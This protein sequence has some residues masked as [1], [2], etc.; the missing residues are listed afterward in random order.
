MDA[1]FLDMIHPNHLTLR[2]PGHDLLH[3][4]LQLREDPWFRTKS[5]PPHSEESF[6]P[7]FDVRVL[8]DTFF[9][10]GEF[11]GVESSDQI[12]LSTIDSN[13]L[14]VTANVSRLDVV[15]EWNLDNVPNVPTATPGNEEVSRHGSETGE[16]LEPRQQVKQ[17]KSAVKEPSIWISE[18]KIGRLQRSFSFPSTVDF[19][20]MRARLGNGILKIMVRQF[21]NS[22]AKNVRNIP[23][24]RTA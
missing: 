12:E 6:S 9:L 14:I 18:R 21:P 22:N 8:D 7:R 13:I 11:P 23:I 4:I 10:E 5:R 17:T 19:T 20:T 3:S 1:R 15:T 16:S 2:E 24:E